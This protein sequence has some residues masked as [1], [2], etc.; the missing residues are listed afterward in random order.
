MSTPQSLFWR[1][2]VLGAPFLTLSSLDAQNNGASEEEVFELTPFEVTAAENSGYMAA[3]TLA[4]TRIRTDLRDV[5]SALSVYTEELMEDVA[6]T[7]SQSLLLYATSAEV[8]GAYS[9]Y[10]GTGNATTVDETSALASPNTNTRVRGLAAAA[11]ARN[12]I[13]TDIPW[14]GF[15]VSRIDLQRGPNAVLF[16]L[17]SPAGLLNA[18][19]RPAEFTDY[20]EIGLRYGSY[21]SYRLS[22]DVNREII[23]GQLGI[24]ASALV[25]HEDFQQD[26]AFEDDERI[27]L[28]AR[29]DPKLFDEG[30][31]QTMI[32]VQYEGGSI[33]ANRPRMI[34]PVDYLTPWF[35]D[36]DSEWGGLGQQFF[37]PYQVED[38]QN[39]AG[40]NRGQRRIADPDFNGW[41][42]SFG[43]TFDQPIGFFDNQTGQLNRYYMGI[44]PNGGRDATGGIDRGINAIP[45]RRLASVSGFAEYAT[46]A[47]LPG[48]Q[49][50]QYRNQ[51]L[52]DASI[53]DFYNNLIDGP[54]KAEWSDWDAFNLSI[55]QTALDGKVGVELVYDRQQ[56]ERGQQ[57][58]LSGQAGIYVD[59]M[60]MLEDFSPNPNAGRA[61]TVG[62]GQY[63]NNSYESDQEDIRLTAFGKVDAADF[64]DRN[65][66]LAK[67]LGRHTFTGLAER[68]KKET[69]DRSW[70]LHGTDDAFDRYAYIGGSG[71]SRFNE[72][73]PAAVIYLSD[74]LTG[75]SAASGAN[76]GPISSRINV[77]DGSLYHFNSTWNADPSVGFGDP[78]SPAEHPVWS[79]QPESYGET[80]SENPDNYVGWSN[81]DLNV[82][83]FEDGD[84]GLYTAAAKEKRQVDT[85]ASVWQSFWWD[86]AVVGL[87]GWRHDKYE[88]HSAQAPVDGQ[89]NRYRLML[90]P[91]VYRYT[92]DPSTI[93]KVT[94]DSMTYGLA[95]HL[96]DLLNDRLPINVSL[97]YSESENFDV[98][99]SNVNLY[100]SAFPNP[101]GDT[102]DYSVMLATKDNRYMFKVTKF[103][104]NSYNQEFEGFSGNYLGGVLARGIA[105]ANVFEYNLSGYTMDTANTGNSG[106]YNYAPAAG[107]TE[108]QA[109]AREAAAVAAWRELAD[110]V[111]PSLYETW[112]IDPDA[113]VS[114]SALAPNGLAITQDTR[115]EG[116]EFEFI[117]NPTKN[118]RISFNASK[119]EATRI[120][121]GDPRT[122]EYV[123]MIGDYLNNTPAGDLRVFWGN[124][125]ATTML[126]QWNQNFAANW[127]LVKLQE[128]AATPEIRK[129]R[130][131]IVTNYSFTE[132]FLDGVN[133]GGS[134]RWQDDVVIGY[135]VVQVDGR[136]TFDIGNPYKGPTEDFVDLWVGYKRML[137]SNVEWSIQLN[138]RNA[139]SDG[140]LVPVSVQPDGETWAAVRIKPE[141]TF[142]LT[143]TF[144][145]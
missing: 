50:G 102:T 72:L 99:P 70:M 9:I 1:L 144:S 26:P 16:G 134:Y 48:Y 42:G 113:V 32:Q 93:T 105:W 24:R 21:G 34:T 95:V 39:I 106:R 62:T 67:L 14:D 38:Q 17:S 69:E 27:Y 127:A 101:S 36:E 132:G 77:N 78:W 109:A 68:Y 112:G 11:N 75:R 114:H 8:G 63:G 143:N 73:I 33:D 100:G 133:I 56:F 136:S 64:L 90:G 2:L 54:N 61:F 96:N 85:F 121:V 123:D 137:T 76:I 116:Y 139:F 20:G 104:T 141:R 51:H 82:L 65:S 107:E 79:Q 3:N 145:F 43:G 94:N 119:T 97:Y 7:D 83:R 92:D 86:G 44:I 5:G 88:S 80:Q 25:D 22:L 117:A 60:S 53:F 124:P 87:V 108:E 110:Q 120:L 84:N 129:W 15:N 19:V 98:G 4:G 41:V 58:L 131:N 45:Y 71:G 57:A 122:T 128:G 130:Y 49:F 138:V 66:F 46:Q 142:Y 103:E 140:G 111:D 74:P 81:Y 52:T 31:G 29:Y 28:A 13:Y 55:S 18:T 30:L 126:A 59:I 91:D 37:D 118:W 23:D 47:Q 40:D 135:P 6:A 35:R 12:F 10:A 125:E 115:S 89:A